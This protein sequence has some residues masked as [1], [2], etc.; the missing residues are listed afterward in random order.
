[1]SQSRTI[2]V[3]QN[4]AKRWI[5]RNGSMQDG[6]RRLPIVSLKLVDPG[7]LLQ[8][9]FGAQPENGRVRDDYSDTL[10]AENSAVDELRDESAIGLA[11]PHKRTGVCA[12]GSPDNRA[13][14]Q[15]VAQ[16]RPRI[17]T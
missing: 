12:E 11:R 7:A 6:N 9:S 17:T 14:K 2:S 10:L 13:E 3:C 4:V 5:W 16:V 8:P 15:R 1:M